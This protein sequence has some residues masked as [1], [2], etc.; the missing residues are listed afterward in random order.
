[1]TTSTMVV[2]ALLHR[3]WAFPRGAFTYA[4]EY[5]RQRQAFGQPIVEFQGIQFLLADLVTRIEAARYLV[6]K[7][8]HIA[9][10]ADRRLSRY[11]AMAKLFALKLPCK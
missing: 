1:M 3:Q 7:A 8:A 10:T 11:A 4:L 6:Y 2:L 5:A 9:D